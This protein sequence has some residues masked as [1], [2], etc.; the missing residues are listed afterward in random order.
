VLGRTVDGRCDQYALGIIAFQMLTGS[1]PFS[2]ETPMA[3]AM[4]QVHEPLP[5]P[6]SRSALVSPPVERVLLVVLSQ[7]PD[8]RYESCG[9]FVSA[10]AAAGHRIVRAVRGRAVR[11][12]PATT[13]G[14]SNSCDN[15]DTLRPVGPGW[16]FRDS[17]DNRATLRDCAGMA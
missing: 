14:R 11:G 8:D 12:A 15:P 5:L 6:R 4:Q 10:L 7:S 2:A 16:R 3:V 1:I 9:A 13:V 17:N